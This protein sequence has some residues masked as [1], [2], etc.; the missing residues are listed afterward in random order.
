MIK[1][2]AHLQNG[3]RLILIGLS[4]GNTDRLH[5]GKP[6]HMEGEQFGLCGWTIGIFAGET[7]Q[8]MLDAL[9]REGVQ[10]PQ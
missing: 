7:E 10:V 1:L 2:S 4:R 5:D 6:I 9:K 3:R 8:D